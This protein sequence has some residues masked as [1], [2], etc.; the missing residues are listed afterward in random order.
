MHKTLMAFAFVAASGAAWAAG[1]DDFVRANAARQAGNLEL[2]LSSYT[3]ALVAGDLSPAFVPNAYLGRAEIYY[4]NGK[5][6]LAVTDLD[7][8]LALRPALGGALQ[9]RAYA[10]DCLGKADIAEADL[11]ALVAAAPAI[12]LYITRG[13]FY[14]RHARFA[15]AGA[16]YAKAAALHDR[17]SFDWQP[18]AFNLLWYAISMSRSQ[19]FVAADFAAKAKGYDLDSWPGPLVSFYLGKAS[20]DAVYREAAKGGNQQK[21]EADFFIAEWQI[22]SGNLAGKTLLQGIPQTC[23]SNA[24]IAVA[25]R[26]ELH[27]IP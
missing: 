21:C 2:A 17:R 12:T 15:Q 5:C 7:A 13:D 8:A 24:Y 18:A 1:Y 19:N 23:S 6:A 20:Q 9:L 16:D 27:R 4:S 22:A 25:A 26:I 3:A 10:N 11:N 14:W